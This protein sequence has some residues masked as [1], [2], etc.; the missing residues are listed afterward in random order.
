MIRRRLAPVWG[1]AAASVALSVFA[2]SA[3]GKGAQ[4]PQ[5]PGAPPVSVATPLV[6]QVVDW[7]DFVGR[8]E[9]P[10]QVEVRARVGG[11]LQ[12]AAFREGQYVRKGQLLFTLDPRPAQAALAAAQA[13]AAQ[14]QAA[15]Q[16][17]ESEL[18][19]AQTLLSAQAV[20]QEEFET[21][22]AAVAQQR[23]ALQAAQ[24][25][26]RARQLDL[27]FT[28][29]TA[30]ISGVVSE[31]RVDPGNLVAGGSSQADVLTTIVASDPIHFAFEASEAQ[32]LKYQRQ[33]RAGGAA[34]VRVR[35]QDEA[36]YR[37]AGVLDFSDNAIDP[38][39]GAVRMRALVQNNGGFLKP[40][41]FGHARVEGSGAYRA[42]LVP[43][44]AIVTDAA[45]K[46]VYVVAQDGTVAAR[47][48]ELGPLSGGLRVIR[49]GL[50]ANERVIV[51]GV[52]RARPG[53][54]VTPQATT[55]SRR[56]GAE[57]QSQPVT[58]APPAS[59]ATPVGALPAAK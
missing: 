7:D 15:L 23:T 19:R 36:D 5:G 37:W 58:S 51:N 27:E 21:R 47:P 4:A 22:R 52:L 57:T 26:V 44:A 41:M 46:V 28:R 29:V 20:S 54:K 59:T 39:S 13:Q 53:Q 40:G 30:P 10:Q 50:G 34:Q 12:T 49:N 18:A 33:Q 11:F 43:E 42:M 56:P 8:F 25:G 2:L 1:G 3:C 35:L 14:V 17:A 6:E 31:R 55:I 9:A 45:R 38:S 48:V 24:A 32:L 16:L